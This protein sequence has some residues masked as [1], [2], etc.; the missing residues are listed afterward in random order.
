MK[1]KKASSIT[2]RIDPELKEKMMQ[3]AETEHRE[4]SD[5]VRH[6]IITYLAK[7]E[8]VKRMTGG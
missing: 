3:Q 2:I 8:E 7:I 4:M 5:F 1:S 6:A